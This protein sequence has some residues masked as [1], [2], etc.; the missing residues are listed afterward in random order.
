VFVK[1]WVNRMPLAVVFPFVGIW[2]DQKLKPLEGICFPSNHGVRAQGDSSFVPI[3]LCLVGT[4]SLT[5]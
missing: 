2:F 3:A 1:M 5:L 4:R